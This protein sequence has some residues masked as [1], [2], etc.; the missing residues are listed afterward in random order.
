MNVEMSYHCRE[1][2]LDRLTL[3]ASTIGWGEPVAVEQ[4]PDR[5][6]ILTDT[7]V[8][9]VMAKDRDFLITAYIP[10]IDKA[11]ALFRSVY[12]KKVIFPRSLKNAIKRNKNL[13]D[14]QDKVKIGD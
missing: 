12:G 1:D 14:I 7:G 8:I 2:R 10:T 13:H 5:R 3:I 6:Q 11:V 4:W 9:M